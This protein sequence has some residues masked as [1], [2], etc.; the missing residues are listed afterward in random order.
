MG[1]VRKTVLK[2]FF[3]GRLDFSTL[4]STQLLCVCVRVLTHL[5]G[6]KKICER[7]L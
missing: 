3:E 7:I 4:N 2:G 6:N 1:S 5:V